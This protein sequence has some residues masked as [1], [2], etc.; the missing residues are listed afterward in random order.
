MKKFN[1]AKVDSTGIS[2]WPAEELLA[3]YC[4]KNIE[5]FKKMKRIAEYGAGYS[6]LAGIALA[7]SLIYKIENP[8]DYHIEISDGNEECANLLADNIELNKSNTQ[9]CHFSSKLKLFMM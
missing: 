2:L 7:K 9:D 6:G 8:Q 3:F 4:L 1:E 5:K